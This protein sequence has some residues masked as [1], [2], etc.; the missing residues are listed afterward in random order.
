M[1][2]IPIDPREEAFKVIRLQNGIEVVGGE[3]H[4]QVDALE[5]I[6]ITHPE[7]GLYQRAGMIVEVSNTPSTNLRI[8]VALKVQRR[9]PQ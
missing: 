6:F 5:Q 7:S 8:L 9:S 4:Q 2:E 3:L 1:T